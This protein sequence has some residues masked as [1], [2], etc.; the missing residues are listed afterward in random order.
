MCLNLIKDNS[1]LNSIT[2]GGLYFGIF[3]ELE[4]GKPILNIIFVGLLSAGYEENI[5]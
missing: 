5:R 2:L 4:G 1:F 3:L